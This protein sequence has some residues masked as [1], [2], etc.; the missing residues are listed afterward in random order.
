MRLSA[1]LPGRFARLTNVIVKDQVSAGTAAAVR[2]Y[3]ESCKYD[4]VLQDGKPLEVRWQV[5][6]NVTR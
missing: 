3:L 5:E 1:T 4:P 2:K 6:F